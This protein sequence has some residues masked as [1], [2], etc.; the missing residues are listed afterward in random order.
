MFT[1]TYMQDYHQGEQGGGFQG[2]TRGLA[3]AA[4]AY[5]PRGWASRGLEKEESR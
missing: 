5:T 2:H 4:T 3:V 1:G